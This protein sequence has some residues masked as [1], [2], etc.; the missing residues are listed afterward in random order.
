[1]TVY[2]EEWKVTYDDGFY[3][4]H[5]RAGKE[6]RIDKEFYWENE[7]WYVPAIYMCTKGLVMDFC[8]KADTSS[9]CAFFEKWNLFSSSYIEHTE[10]EQEKIRQEHPLNID[11]QAKL[12]MNQMEMSQTYAYGRTWISPNCIP[13]QTEEDMEERLFELGAD[14]E[15]KRFLEHYGYDTNDTWI[16]RRVGFPWIE[17]RPRSMKSL[18]LKLERSKVD[19]C[20]NSFFAPKRN[21]T[22]TLTH[23]NSKA[24]YLLTLREYHIQELENHHFGT[25]DM[26]YPT[27][28]HSMTYTIY[29]EL[30]DFYIAD[31]KNGDNPR[32]KKENPDGPIGFSTVGIL[33]IPRKEDRGKYVHTDG[34]IAT[35]RVACSSVYFEPIDKVEW[36]IVFKEKQMDDVE[37]VLVSNKSNKSS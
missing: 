4:Q 36:K 26:E 20:G 1:M 5:G 8:V 12:C 28:F 3:S 7:H 30:Q 23:P 21:E 9:V 10:E 29:P 19:I 11:F 31:C 13:N 24:E 2:E 35:T 6:I 27:H 18:D 17:K 34:S 37:V 33:G 14:I 16:I 25:D 32:V 15:A 22:I